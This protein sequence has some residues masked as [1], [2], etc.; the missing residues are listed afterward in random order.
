MEINTAGI[1][2]KERKMEK[3]CMNLQVEIYMRGIGGMGRGQERG[4]IN[5]NQERNIQENGLMI[6]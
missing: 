4:F 2:M 6:K 3:E 1:G 5:G